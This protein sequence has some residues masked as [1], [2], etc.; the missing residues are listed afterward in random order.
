MYRPITELIM[1]GWPCILSVT[2]AALAC[3]DTMP[4]HV[5]SIPLF[6]WLGSAIHF[7]SPYTLLPGSSLISQGKYCT[8]EKYKWHT[9]NFFKGNSRVQTNMHCCDQDW[10]SVG[11]FFFRDLP[12]MSCGLLSL[13]G[14]NFHHT[15]LIR[16]RVRPFSST[17]LL[18]C[19]INADFFT[20]SFISRP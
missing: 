18:L 3:C 16:K 4:I 1:L 13:A 5:I 15:I 6:A 7:H 11:L 12:A 20:F 17:P 9:A 2:E 14:I 10:I 19:F 8:I